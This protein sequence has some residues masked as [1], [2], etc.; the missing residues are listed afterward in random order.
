VLLSGALARWSHHA[1]AAVTSS[2][3]AE[4]VPANQIQRLSIDRAAADVRA[5]KM[6]PWRDASSGERPTKWMLW[7]IQAGFR[8]AE[9][10]PC[11]PERRLQ[12]VHR[13]QN[14]RTLAHDQHFIQPAEPA[15]SR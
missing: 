8:T 3:G 2:G 6:L 10:R 5:P 15:R 9:V 7:V 14:Q 4:L 11:C 12:H 13:A 1:I